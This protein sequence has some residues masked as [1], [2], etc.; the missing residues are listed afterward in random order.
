MQFIG[1]AAVTGTAPARAIVHASTSTPTCGFVTRTGGSLILDGKP[2]RFGGLNE[3]PIRAAAL[4]HNYAHTFTP[5]AQR[6]K[7]Y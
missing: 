3:V 7:P 2:F 6:S 5:R 4:A 1:V